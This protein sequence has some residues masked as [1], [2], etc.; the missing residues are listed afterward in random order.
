MSSHE[1]VPPLVLVSDSARPRLR[2]DREWMEIDGELLVLTDDGRGLRHFDR[3]AAAIWPHLDGDVTVQ[4]LAEG[5]GVGFGVDVDVVR[6]AVHDFV[7]R[8]TEEGLLVPSESHVPALEERPDEWGY[9]TD[10][11]SP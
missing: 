5:L 10:P 8:L 11:P 9:L 7:A 4:D 6:P 2:S 1:Q 3:I